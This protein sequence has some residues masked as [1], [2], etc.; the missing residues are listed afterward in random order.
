MFSKYQSVKLTSEEF[1]VTSCCNVTTW[2][3]SYFYGEFYFGNR[4]DGQFDSSA[5]FKHL[6]SWVRFFA[7]M[8]KIAEKK[9]ASACFLK[10]LH[11]PESLLFKNSIQLNNACVGI[12]CNLSRVLHLQHRVECH[13]MF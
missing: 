1:V 11:L 7:N 5:A 9:L 13:V 2:L 12:T 4:L 8:L 10:F 3:V 6:A